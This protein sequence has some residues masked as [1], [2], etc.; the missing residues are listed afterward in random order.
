MIG[1]IF[2]I[3]LY[4]LSFNLMIFCIIVSLPFWIAYS[5]GMT[6][7]AIK[8]NI[9][10]QEMESIRIYESMMDEVHELIVEFNK[11]DIIGMFM[12][13][14]DVFHSICKYLVVKYLSL[15]LVMKW[16]FWFLLYWF[17]V[18]AS[19]KHGYRFLRYRCIRNHNNKSNLNHKCNYKS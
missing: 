16:Y 2:L 1:I 3:L 12:E 19:L 17:V 6:E 15:D 5:I 9:D 11:R 13:F 14:Y 4:G 18:P 7:Y 8:N 10:G